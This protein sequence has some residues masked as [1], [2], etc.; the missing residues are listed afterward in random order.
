MQAA[1]CL[2]VLFGSLLDGQDRA[3][4]LG[5]QRARLGER[6]L[7]GAALEQRHAQLV[8]QFLHGLADRGLADVQTP[9]RRARSSC[10]RATTVKIRSRC[11][12]MLITSSHTLMKK[13]YL[14]YTCRWSKLSR[15]VKWRCSE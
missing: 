15:D 3:P 7:A 11:S 6:Q 10:A 8:L 12:F 13:M 5:Q 9:P 4:S 14:N 2:Q 1:Q